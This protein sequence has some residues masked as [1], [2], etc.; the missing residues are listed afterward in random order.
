[1][2]KTNHYVLGNDEPARK[3]S[4][5]AGGAHSNDSK[6]VSTVDCEALV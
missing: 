6:P 4:K 5:D 2:S 1:M 3:K